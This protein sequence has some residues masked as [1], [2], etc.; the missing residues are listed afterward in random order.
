[1]GQAAA[2]GG[3]DEALVLIDEEAEG[4]GI[5]EGRVLLECLLVGHGVVPWVEGNLHDSRCA[6]GGGESGRG[7]FFWLQV[8]GKG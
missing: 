8:R 6:R 2:G 7:W 3:V 1:M 5:L 4:L